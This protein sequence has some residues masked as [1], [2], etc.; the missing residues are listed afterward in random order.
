MLLEQPS[1]SRFLHRLVSRSLLS[2]SL[3]ATLLLIVAVHP[4]S[5]D[6]GPWLKLATGSCADPRYTSD[7]LGGNTLLVLSGGLMPNSPFEFIITARDGNVS[8]PNL[9]IDQTVTADS[10]GNVCAD[11]FPTAANDYGQYGITIH[12]LRANQ[13][14]YNTFTVVNVHAVPEPTNTPVPT[15]TPAPTAT[16]E[17]T[18]TPV[19]THTPEPTATVEPTSTSEPAN[20]PAPTA[21]SEPT[22]T[23]EPADTPAPTATSEPTSTSEPASTPAPATTSTPA[24]T[25]PPTLT[26]T[27]EPVN[28]L[29]PTIAPTTT[30]KPE[31]TGE[32]TLTPLP[33]AVPT[34]VPDNT[35]VP[36]VSAPQTKHN[37]NQKQ[38]NQGKSTPEPTELPSEAS[39]AV[40]QSVTGGAV[41]TD[42]VSSTLSPSVAVSFS[43]VRADRPTTQQVATSSH[44]MQVNTSKDQGE[45]NKSLPTSVRPNLKSPQQVTPSAS[46]S[47][48]SEVA[49][50]KSAIIN[51]NVAASVVVLGTLITMCAWFISQFR[52]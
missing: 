15:D 17:P 52:K 10:N 21:T 32:P 19:P 47:A 1:N 24:P 25:D 18:S 22:S 27:P 31:P 6:D 8:Q 9:N 48:A 40:A 30:P 43:G 36:V 51:P 16:I 38:S 35:P 14:S 33:T 49:L 50:Q 23:S 41:N 39:V 13:Q 46:A 42:R 4:A 44:E 34:N 37:S 7:L 2:L 28:T 26:A 29:A 20:T 45:L 11:A 3:C 12:G 5:A